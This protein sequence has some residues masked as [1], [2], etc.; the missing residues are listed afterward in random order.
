MEQQDYIIKGNKNNSLLT[1]CP[2]YAIFMFE[3]GFLQC[4]SYWLCQNCVRCLRFGMAILIIIMC[5]VRVMGYFGVSRRYTTKLFNAW[6]LWILWI[7]NRRCFIR[8]VYIGKNALNQHFL[9]DGPNSISSM[10]CC[11]LM[12]KYSSKF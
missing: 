3:V 11:Q 6:L 10:V 9:F 8:C 12:S 5:I 4:D 7:T 1:C 2:D